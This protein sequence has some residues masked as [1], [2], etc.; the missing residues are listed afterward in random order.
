MNW[1]QRQR[2]EDVPQA[3]YFFI[4]LGIFVYLLE[5]MWGGATNP[6]TLLLMG[7]NAGR[8]VVQEGEYW[9]LMTAIFLHAGLLH[10]ALNSYVLFILGQ[11][12]EGIL[13]T[14]RFVFLF[15]LSGVGGS[16]ASIYVG[17]AQL[18][19][20]ASGAIWGLF[21]A[22]LALS[23]LPN[24]FIPEHAREQ[25]RKMMLMN[26]LINVF[27]SFLP[28]VDMW[29]H[30]GG[31]IFGFALTMLYMRKLPN[32]VSVLGAA[33][34][35]LMLG[36]SFLVGYST[37]QPWRYQEMLQERYVP[38]HRLPVREKSSAPKDYI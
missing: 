21:G 1:N 30:F 37:Y 8:L 20:G 31:G 28:M 16:L 29:G 12:I 27:V 26:L 5:M 6:E 3:T 25:I 14:V 36:A 11:F 24:E 17:G 13:G 15:L 9:R 23:L 10:I 34:F 4:G 38:M 2:Q 7:G 35:I 18:S 22:G 33:I 32:W 19:V